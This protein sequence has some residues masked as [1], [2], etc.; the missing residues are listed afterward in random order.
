MYIFC[1]YGTDFMKTLYLTDLDGTLLNQNA[2]VSKETADI[3]NFL[4]GKGMLFSV[5]TARTYATVIP[6]MKEVSLALPMVLMNGVSIFDPV[7]RTPVR[8]H[9]LNKTAAKE[10][11]DLFYSRGRY[12]MLYFENGGKITVEY[13]KLQTQPQIDYVAHRKNFYDK[14]F[15]EVSQYS[16]D[17]E[18]DLIYI[19]SLDKAENT[20]PVF[21]VVRKRSDV[22]SNFY[23]DNYCDE[24]FLEIYSKNASKAGG[25]L[26]VKKLVGADRIVAFGDNL[27]DLSLFE[28][29]DEAYAVS[30]ACD[31]LKSA[32]TGIIGAN[33]QNAVA[34]FLLER[35]NNG[36]L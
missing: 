16:L 25:A 10:I 14:S 32:A 12:P 34:H 4:I 7:T 1:L 17:G 13:I 33:T 3:L 36:T 20:A 28:I 5:A 9:S 31:E 19:A 15:C 2:S 23:P 27:N 24:F 18:N 8:Y 26:E 30:N 11:L 22:L 21:E 35:Y 29:A 6:M